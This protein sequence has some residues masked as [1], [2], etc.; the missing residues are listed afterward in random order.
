MLLLIIKDKEASP[1]A[2]SM[3]ADSQFRKRDNPTSSPKRNSQDRKPSKGT[4]KIVM[5]ML[6]C[7][8]PQEWAS[9]GDGGGCYL[10]C[11]RK[12]HKTH[13][14]THLKHVISKEWGKEEEVWAGLS[15]RNMGRGPLLKV[16]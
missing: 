10:L 14:K 9:G 11:R 3:T 7:S 16:M 5:R 8:S 12:D 15:G 13:N 2:V 6:Q 1:A 4:L